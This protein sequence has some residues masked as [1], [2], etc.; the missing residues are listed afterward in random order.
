MYAAKSS[1]S[2]SPAK[3]TLIHE[4]KGASGRRHCFQVQA[5]PVHLR[6]AQP[7]VYLFCRQ[8]ATGW[9]A[10]ALGETENLA[11]VCGDT[12]ERAAAIAAGATHV[13]LHI[14][15]A[16]PAARAEEYAD[17]YAALFATPALLATC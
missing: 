13:H 16:G 14:R 7:G 10:L 15:L 11:T 3:V 4:W 2:S 12:P 6:T 5:L 9:Q 8:T 17:L 1:R